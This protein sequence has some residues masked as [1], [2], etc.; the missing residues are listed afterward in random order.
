MLNIKKLAQRTLYFKRFVTSFFGNPYYG[1][2]HCAHDVDF[3]TQADP[4][5]S[6]YPMD[7]SYKADYPYGSDSEGVPLLPLTTQHWATSDSIVYN[8]IVIVQ[9]GL[10]NHTK[11]LSTGECSCLANFRSAIQWTVDHLSYSTDG[12]Y[13]EFDYFLAEQPVR[14]AMA[15]GLVISL[16]LRAADSDSTVDYGVEIDTLVKGILC[17]LDQG[18]VFSIEDGLE[19]LQEYSNEPYSILNGHIFALLGLL[20]YHNSKYYKPRVLPEG[21]IASLLNS[22]Y[23][24][25]LRSDCGFWSYYSLRKGFPANYASRFYHRLHINLLTIL[26]MLSKDGKYADIIKR[27]ERYDARLSFRFVAMVMKVVD[28]FFSRGSRARTG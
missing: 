28:R 12:G 22:T 10:G 17:P 14:S 23:Q 26:A 2:W 18:G 4:H 25:T 24:L 8:P 6:G 9:W 16:L 13:L 20:E 15:N 21:R 3:R 1:Y 27:F 19:V 7:F 5:W 11:W